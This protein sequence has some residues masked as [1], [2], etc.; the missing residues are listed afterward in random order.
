MKSTEIAFEP[1]VERL[2]RLKWPSGRILILGAS[3]VLTVSWLG[4]LVWATSK[5]LDLL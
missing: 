2:D 3:L 4:F 1:D 5:F